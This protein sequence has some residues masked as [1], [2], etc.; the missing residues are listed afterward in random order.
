V[1]PSVIILNWP[2]LLLMLLKAAYGDIPRYFRL[3]AMT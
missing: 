1:S 2:Q 3:Y